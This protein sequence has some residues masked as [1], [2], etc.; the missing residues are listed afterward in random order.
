[1]SFSPKSKLCLPVI[2]LS[3]AFLL[4]V[5]PAVPQ[6]SDKEKE[7]DAKSEKSEQARE[8]SSDAGEYCDL[9][10]E[11]TAGEKGEPVDQASVYVKFME[12]RALRRDKQVALNLKTN[13][14][15]VARLND[16]P[17][18][19]VLIQVI[20]PGWKTFGQWYELDKAEQTVKI[21]LQK[22]PRWY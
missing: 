8:K 7:K 22:P 4:A 10:V 14:Q 13:S 16:A 20:A 11:I 21:R 17:R 2:F 18:G 3:L 6:G 5:P 15:G 1:M 12:S 19:K 9:R